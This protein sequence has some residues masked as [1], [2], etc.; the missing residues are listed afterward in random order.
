MIKYVLFDLDGTLLSTLDTITY[1]LNAALCA[2][3]LGEI[4]VENTREYIV[5]QWGKELNNFVFISV[6]D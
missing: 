6:K 2:H 4:T 5:Y 1:H 3:G